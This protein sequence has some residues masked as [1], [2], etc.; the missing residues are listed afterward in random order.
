MRQV[1]CVTN[2]PLLKDAYE[3]VEFLDAT[4]QEVFSRARDLIHVGWHF[5][6]HPEYGN[7]H[8]ARNPFRTLVLESPSGAG[9][10]VDMESF[11]MLEAALA[12]LREAR[13]A[14]EMSETTR[15]DYATLDAELMRDTI[16]RYLRKSRN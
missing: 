12:K 5:L 11:E 6:G 7:M 15:S 8:P 1:L 16:G 10:I 13:S 3:C 14:P 2:N 4:P 9:N